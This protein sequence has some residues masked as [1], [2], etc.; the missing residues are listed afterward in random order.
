MPTQY[1]Y[2]AVTPDIIGND[3]S[4]SA[5]GVEFCFIKFGITLNP[6]LEVLRSGYTTHN[7]SIGFNKMSY[8]TNISSI[9]KT[10][11]L[12]RA[13]EQVINGTVLAKVGNTEWYLAP[14]DRALVLFRLFSEIEASGNIIDKDSVRYILNRLQGAVRR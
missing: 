6:D 10:N 4:L 12:G 5:A 1:V 14:K 9:T 2:C 8:N 13:I 11:D 7:P 3:W